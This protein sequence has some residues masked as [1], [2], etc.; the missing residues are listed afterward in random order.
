MSPI[1][2]TEIKSQRNS[3]THKYSSDF[4]SSYPHTTRNAGGGGWPRVTAGLHQIPTGRCP[5]LG[6]RPPPPAR[7][8]EGRRCT[9]WDILIFRGQ[10]VDRWSAQFVTFFDIRLE[11]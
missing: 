11:G 10:R 9:R 5:T 1:G 2:E 3:P 7:T 4:Y 8:R 6:E